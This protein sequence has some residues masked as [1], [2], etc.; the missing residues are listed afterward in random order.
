MFT[1]KFATMKYKDTTKFNAE[2]SKFISDRFSQI[3]ESIDYWADLCVKYIIYINAGGAIA[4]LTFMGA[5]SAVRDMIGSKLALLSFVFGLVAAGIVLAVGFYRMA[6]FQKSLKQDSA[7]YVSNE[8]DW[9]ELLDNDAKRLEPSKWACLLGWGA[10]IFFGLGVI[11]GLI[12]LFTY[13]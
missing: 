3:I 5:S 9:E 8:I 7:K 1:R 13:K 12:S 4:V 6:H 11:I 10:F 2:C